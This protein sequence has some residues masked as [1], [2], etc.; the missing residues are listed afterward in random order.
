MRTGPENEKKNKERLIHINGYLSTLNQNTDNVSNLSLR[1]G[2]H[3]GRRA[4][5][6][7]TEKSCR[8]I[9]FWRGNGLLTVVIRFSATRPT[10]RSIIVMRS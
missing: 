5:G 7:R 10:T 3:M 6:Q 8:A 1:Y 9:T 4:N 2:D